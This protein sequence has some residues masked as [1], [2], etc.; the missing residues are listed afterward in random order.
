MKKYI[1]ILSLAMVAFSF[2]S[3]LKD[4]NFDER[5][6]GHDLTGV[7]KVIELAIAYSPANG[8]TVGLAYVDNLVNAEVLTVRLAAENP[9]PEDINVTIDTTGA[10]SFIN[11]FN[12]ANGS[13]IVKLPNSFYTMPSTGYVVTI[14]KG[15]R[16]ASIVIKTNAIQYNTSTT[17]ALFYTIKS[18]DKPGY[19]ISQNFGKYFTRLGA[20]NKYDGVYTVTG[21]MVDNTNA[22]FV[23]RY[24]FTYHLVT[25]GANSV[26]VTQSINGAF[27]P[28][29]LFSANGAGSFFGNFGV[30]IIF[31]PVTDQIAEIRN[32]YG[33]PSNAANGIGDPSLGTGAPLY[34]ASNTRRATLDPSGINAYDNGAKEI[35]I[36]FFMLQPGLATTQPF[37]GV[38]CR[39]TERMVY[40]GPRP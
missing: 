3:C 6:T 5:R 40:T 30:S 18:V 24:P 1:Q 38:R 22:T 20:K 2:A 27:V 10:Q 29:Y 13:T 35:N 19:I 37:G 25:T 28:G 34:A 23:G 39:M 12:T 8:R 31:D 17:Y 32:Y 26:D 11:D 21:S 16:E 4:K 7:P 15:K 9:A 36:K 33:V 14:P